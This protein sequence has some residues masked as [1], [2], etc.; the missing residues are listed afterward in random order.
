MAST[1]TSLRSASAGRGAASASASAARR[2]P[3]VGAGGGLTPRTI[4]SSRLISC[5]RKAGSRQNS[6]KTWA[7]TARCSG[8]ET[9]Q[10]CSVW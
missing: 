4:G 9:K 10:A 8:R 1:S 2:S 5:S 3:G 6:R 7:K